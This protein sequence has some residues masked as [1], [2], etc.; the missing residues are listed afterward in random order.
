MEYQDI[1][2]AIPLLSQVRQSYYQKTALKTTEQLQIPLNPKA[3]GIYEETART[4]ATAKC[5]KRSKADSE[6]EKT[7]LSTSYKPTCPAS[8]QPSGIRSNLPKEMKA[9]DVKTAHEA[10][11]YLEESKPLFNMKK[12]RSRDTSKTETEKSG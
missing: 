2:Q 11:G 7:Q 6:M 5:F 8:N 4:S 1:I 10:E 12:E 9:A 3:N